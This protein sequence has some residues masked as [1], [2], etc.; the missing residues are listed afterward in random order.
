[1]GL[2]RC[3]IVKVSREQA[4]KPGGQCVMLVRAMGKAY[5]PLCG[6]RVG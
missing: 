6:V 4:S 3:K 2:M 1:M 5:L